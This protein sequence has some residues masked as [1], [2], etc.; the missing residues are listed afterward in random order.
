MALKV[1]W[2]DKR[3]PEIEQL[4][5]EVVNYN[6]LLAWGAHHHPDFD[7]RLR[8]AR[9]L[10]DAS[11][12]RIMTEF[13]S[14]STGETDSYDLQYGTGLMVIKHR[15]EPRKFGFGEGS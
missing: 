15:A 9:E 8:Y 1:I 14:A 12:R 11:A 2:T 5:D 4:M 13:T 10:S 6:R 7:K 3:K